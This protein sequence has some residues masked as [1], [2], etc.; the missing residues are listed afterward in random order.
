M[1]VNAHTG[2]RQ[3]TGGLEGPRRKPDTGLGFPP[4]TLMIV[5]VVL[6]SPGARRRSVVAPDGDPLHFGIRHS[7]RARAGGV[8]RRM[9]SFAKSPG[10]NPGADTETGLPPSS[11]QC[12]LG[13]ARLSLADTKHR[14]LDDLVRIYSQ[15]AG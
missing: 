15:V 3:I 14:L 4:G 6:F 10:T 2:Y 11:L 7:D 13:F 9:R 8:K 5:I 1:R 12:T